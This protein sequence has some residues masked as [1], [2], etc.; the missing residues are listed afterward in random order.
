MRRNKDESFWFIL[1][2]VLTLL[3]AITVTGPF[4]A[5]M[6][7]KPDK[8]SDR[9]RDGDS[10]VVNTMPS[11]NP[12]FENY[13]L[14]FNDDSGLY[15]ITV[16]SSVIEDGIKNVAKTSEFVEK[17][18]QELKK[19]YGS[20]LFQNEIAVLWGKGLPDDLKNVM[21]IPKSW[22]LSQGSFSG[23]VQD[24]TPYIL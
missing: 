15:K 13:I 12:L 1:F 4:G 19:E 10:F 20:P 7:D 18:V 21:I 16:N 5:N 14:S 22:R 6:G 3:P 11:P 2:A 8:Y 23:S 17:A 24:R 9:Q